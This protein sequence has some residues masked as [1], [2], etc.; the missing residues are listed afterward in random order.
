MK[1]EELVELHY[2]AP[3][4]NMPSIHVNGILSHNR[5]QKVQHQSIAMPEIQAL[6]AKVIVPGGKRLHD[7]VNLYVHGRNP[8]MYKRKDQHMTLC[9]LRVSTA[10]LDLPGVVVTS[11][12]A[13][14][15]YIRFVPAPRGLEVVDRDLAFAQYWIH[16]DPIEHFRR[17]VARCAEVLVPDRVDPPLILG[18]Y[19]SCHQ[20]REVLTTTLT[21]VMITME[22][23]VQ[24]DL[25]FQK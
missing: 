22:V 14:S 3:L 1:R 5:A 11:G 16:H 12:N 24:S 21:D 9:V 4:D 25:F 7:Y 17:S 2:I 15:S 13:S 20:S 19:V 23:V 6:R 8:M 10:V 18:A